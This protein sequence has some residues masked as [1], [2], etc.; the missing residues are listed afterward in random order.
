MF[1]RRALTVLVTALVAGLI[2]AGCGG[3][4][5][6]GS[7]NESKELNLAYIEWDENVAVS[8]LTKVLMEEEL[9]YESV[10]LQLVDVGAAY[11]SVASGDVDGWQDAWLPGQQNYLDEVEDQVEVFEP[12]YEGQTKYGIAVLDYMEGI[13]TIGDLENTDLDSITGIEPGAAFHAQIND[14]VIPEYN[15]NMDLVESST[16]AMLAEV[17]RAS[18]NQEPVAFLAWAPHWMNSKYNIRYLEDPKNA[19]GD[20][21]E[22]MDVTTIVRTD[23]AD[24]NP[25]AYEFMQ[26]ISLS[27]EEINTLEADI[28][29]AGAENPEEGVKAWLEDNQDVV[30]P[31]LDAANNA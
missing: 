19:Q 20:F 11:Q 5:E 23:L 7:Q 4:G 27:P 22:P 30:Q 24:D 31:W 26:A 29:E 2:V 14:T 13:Q 1:I 6:S 18:N 28:Q 10:E 25:V 15:L 16:P 8:N 21:D 3:G 17:Q 12:W 9:G